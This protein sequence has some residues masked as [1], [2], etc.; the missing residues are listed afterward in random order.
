MGSPPC[1]NC[2]L[3]LIEQARDGRRRA[4]VDA[5]GTRAPSW[6]TRSGA[7]Y[8][9]PLLARADRSRWAHEGPGAG[10]GDGPPDQP[11]RR[12]E[13][14]EPACAARTRRAGPGSGS[15]SSWG[16]RAERGTTCHFHPHLLPH[17]VHTPAGAADPTGGAW[18]AP[19][20]TA[21][22]RPGSLRGMSLPDRT[23]SD[24]T[25]PRSGI[26][27]VRRRG[28][29][30]WFASCACGGGAVREWQLRW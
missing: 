17:R 8:S 12:R 20:P 19:C 5:A 28:R 16:P 18:L 13:R 27:R 21:P 25:S 3:S 14:G 23:A 10:Q 22:C 2:D 11:R 24:P 15:P 26:T 30:P 7:G 4:R 6:R 9:H 1:G 29:P